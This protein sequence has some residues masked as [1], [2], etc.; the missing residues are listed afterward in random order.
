MK[1]FHCGTCNAL[2]FFE[3]SQCLNCGS[4]LAF[5]PDQGTMD[6][7]T[8]SDDGLWHSARESGHR[9]RLCANFR[10]R[11]LCNWAVPAHDDH[12][13]CQSCRL[14]TVTPDPTDSAQQGNWFKLE[15]AK[16][17]LLCSLLSLGL[18]V[19]SKTDDP[20][21]GL[22]FEFKAPGDS[23]EAEPV[24]TGH[25]SGIITI[26]AL[27]ADDVERETRRQQLHEPYRTVLGHFRHEIGHYYWDR[28]IAGSD[29]LEAFRQLFGDEQQDY[30]E[31]LK[32]HY[33]KGPSP[34]W[35]Q[36]FVSAYASSHPWEDWAETWAHY[37]HLTDTIETAAASGLMLRPA[38]PEEPTL[39]RRPDLETGNFDRLLSDWSALTY[40]LNNLNRGLGLTDA[41]PFVLPGPAID[42]LRF[43]HETVTGHG[44]NVSAAL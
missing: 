44:Q 42:K 39:K 28:L 9:Y 20:E 25:A 1:V 5:L 34:D 21:R 30:A 41:Y 43:V 8:P 35:P 4:T 6:S 33:D 12:P 26:N 22:A 14:T 10:E 18:P 16:R 40:L 36:H 23:P 15:A 29:R 17:R 13:L 7:L 38:N 2:V 24:L 31:A 37:M 32:A 19:V 11:Q 3:N 27:E